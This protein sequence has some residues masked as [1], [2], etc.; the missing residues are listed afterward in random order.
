MYIGPARSSIRVQVFSFSFFLLEERHACMLILRSE[1]QSAD[2]A[3]YFRKIHA[4]NSATK[5][6]LF[7]GTDN[8]LRTYALGALSRIVN[9][10]EDLQYQLV[11]SSAVTY[12]YQ[13]TMRTLPYTGSAKRSIAGNACNIELPRKR[14][15]TL[16]T[17][18]GASLQHFSAQEDEQQR[19]FNQTI[20]PR[21][22][23]RTSINV[24]S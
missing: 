14:A 19:C 2:S 21:S 23:H 18:E 7:N 15:E 10:N 8:E 4:R 3:R 20:E 16:R 5:Q 22:T 24:Q 1:A 9:W 12:M 13:S 6:K 11:F 17:S